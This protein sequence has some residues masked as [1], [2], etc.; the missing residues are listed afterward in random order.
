MGLIKYVMCVAFVVPGF[1]SK[2]LIVYR[3]RINLFEIYEH[4]HTYHDFASNIIF[5]LACVTVLFC[6]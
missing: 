3:A 5:C 2:V 1:D 6:L 4:I